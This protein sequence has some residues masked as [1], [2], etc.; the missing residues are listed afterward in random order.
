MKK[1]L[2]EQWFLISLA[3]L[4]IAVLFDSSNILAKAGIFLKNH[5]GPEF[6]IFMIFFISGLMIE[7]DQVKAGVKD[8]KATVLALILILVAA[9]LAALGLSVFPME[10]GVLAGLFIVASMP[11]TLS[12]GVVMTGMAG[13]NMAHALFVTILSNF[14]GIFSI[15]LIL[16]SLMSSLHYD[17]QLAIDQHAIIIKLFILVVCP[18]LTGMAVK[19]YLLK[20]NDTDL[21]GLQIINQFLV[22]GVVFI[23]LAGA[24]DV[25]LSR[26]WIFSQV[27][28]LAAGFH[29]LLLTSSFVLIKLSGI[30][31]GR[32]ES[33]IF[34]G[35]QKTLPLSVMI[36]VT[37]FSEFG[38]ALLVLVVHHVLHLMIDGYLSTRMGKRN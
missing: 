31:K 17:Q 4:F 23:S 2:K 33:V 13:G 18:L 8:I 24:K 5:H 34:M 35:S 22:I 6:M 21:S 7:N 12:S 16:S 14:I 38:T 30:E 10:T 25:L 26:G 3:F 37:Y 9:P 1:T 28:L 11:T 15:P 36:Q 19:N 20:K 27:V 29:L 32:R